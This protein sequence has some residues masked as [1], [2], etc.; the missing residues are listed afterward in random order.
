MDGLNYFNS[1]LI[2][3]EIAGQSVGIPE[4]T[5]NSIAGF[6]QIEVPIGDFL[7][8]G[9]VRHERFNVDFENQLR[10]DGTIFEGGEIDYSATLYNA[11][12][13]Y[14]LT[15]SEELFAGF[16]QGFDVT[17]PG[18]AASAVDSVAQIRLEPAVTDNFEIGARTTREDW[19]ASLAAFYTSPTSRRARSILVARSCWPFRCASPRRSGASRGRWTSSPPV[20]G[21]SAAPS[22]IR[23]ATA[24]LTATPDASRVGS[25]RRSA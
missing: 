16:T 7:L 20:T 15:D 2:Q 3:S 17:Q 12:L 24:R 13:V 5:Q 22:P 19:Q 18:R 11:G 6:G 14:F 9:G 10:G 21:R 23:K 8:S 4:I 1:D 25:S